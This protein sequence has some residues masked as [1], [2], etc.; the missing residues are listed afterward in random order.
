[1]APADAPFILELV[2]TPDWIRNIGDRG[3]RTPEDARDYIE[4]GP[5]AMYERLGFGLWIA[6]LRDSSEPVGICGLIKRDEL[7]D[8]DL[9]FALLPRYFGQ[10]YAREAATATMA[11]GRDRL[12][13]GRIVAITVPGNAD[14]VKLLER[15]GFRFERTIRMAHKDEAVSL[16][17]SLP[18]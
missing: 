6:E 1:M 2:N 3:M 13:L 15:L 4:K 14:S 7:D 12:G 16:Y 11:Y 8:V 5:M 18:A 17:A 9:G 10:G